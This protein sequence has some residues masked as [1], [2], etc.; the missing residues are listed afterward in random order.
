M[1]A[2]PGIA[3]YKIRFE[4]S[5]AAAARIKIM[6]EGI[7]LQEMKRD[8]WLS[9]YSFLVAD[10]A[11]QRN[12]NS[13]FILGLLKRVLEARRDFKAIVSSATINTRVF[14]DI[15]LNSL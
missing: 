4:D 8:P 12:L 5:A 1:G 6:T 7:L 14:E 15:S 3:A 10:E 9:K 13:D 2:K 11:Q